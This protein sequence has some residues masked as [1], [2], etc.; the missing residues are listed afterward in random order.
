M[1][2]RSANAIFWMFRYLERAEN[3]ARLL[4]TGF[5]MALTR[6]HLTA[7]EEWRSVIETAGMRHGYAAQN[8]TYAGIQVW[9]YI[10]R[11]R[12]NP[13]SIRSLIGAVRSNARSARNSIT[14]ELWEAVNES[15][16][17]LNDLLARPVTQSGLADAINT[18]KRESTLVRGAMDGSMLRNDIYNFARIGSF[19][20]RAD[21]TARIIDVK[22]YVLLPSLSYVG[23]SLDNVQWETILRS[24]GAERA[25]RW[26]NAGQLDAR[27][28]ANFLILD[29]Q[30]P[31][32]L[33]FC[34]AK[35]RS[36][37]H[38]LALQYGEK[39]SSNEA[40]RKADLNLQDKDIDAV[41]EQGLHEFLS[42]FIADTHDIATAVET[43]YRFTD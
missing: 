35:I 18:V 14:T 39:L 4:D 9:N 37:L 32:S 40:M 12:D 3:L 13:N 27:G 33:R 38:N 15:Y 43:D 25:Y 22:Y 26:L 2:G 11:D 21:N 1:L 30:F 10:L 16:L 20:E 42:D 23:S 19:V 17:Q 36:N 7:E 34:Y 31:R 28:I 8:G 29:G 6:D 24:L 41:L 5:R